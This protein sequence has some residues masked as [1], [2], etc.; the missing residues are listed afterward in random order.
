M[1]IKA[2][3]ILPVIYATIFFSMLLIIIP[4]NSVM[5]EEN[6]LSDFPEE[7]RQRTEEYI[8]S[9]NESHYFDLNSAIENGESQDIIEFGEIFN[10]INENNPE[11]SSGIV[12]DP[13]QFVT[14]GLKNDVRKLSRYGNWCGPGN[15]GKQSV[16][17]VLDLSCARHDVCYAQKGWGNRACNRAFVNDI[18]KIRRSKQWRKLSRAGQLY[19]L[20][21]RG[22]FSRYM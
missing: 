20:A 7:F 9:N 18:D 16:I 17:D 22:V 2:K 11:G 6:L 15:K 13:D 19:A 21:A 12:S 8:V 10:A 4:G 14:F 5:A 1:F 3:N